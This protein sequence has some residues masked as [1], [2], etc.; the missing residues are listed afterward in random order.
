MERYDVIVCGGGSAG[1]CTA[2]SAA[3][4]GCKTA[5]IEKYGMP[6]G[7]LTV[8]GNSSI[9]QFNNPFLHGN[10][11]VIGG[12]GWEFVRRLAA[13]G[14][15]RIPDMCAPYRVHWQYGVKVNPVAAAALMDRMLLDSGVSLYYGQPVVAVDASGAHLESVTISTKSGLRK[16]QASVFVDCT[17]D[18]DVCAWAGARYEA[19]DGHEGYQP[20]TLRY[21]PVGMEYAS[22]DYVLD[23]GDNKNHVPGMDATDSDALT[24]A[25]IAARSQMLEKM[26][27]SKQGGERVMAVAPAVGQREGRRISGKAY[28]HSEEYIAGKVFDDSV[29]YSFWFVDIHRESAPAC[30]RYITDGATPTVRLR[31]MMPQGFSNLLCAGRCVSSDRETNSALRVKGSCMAMGEAAGIAAAFTARMAVPDTDALDIEIVKRSL[32]HSGAIVPGLTPFASFAA[33]MEKKCPP[34]KPID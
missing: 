21:Y 22:D 34:L 25:E 1:F 26:L 20:G 16:L 9:D 7:V 17:G 33:M 14:F 11:M 31:A 27:H 29:C 10:N 12:I 32:H 5:L 3:R 30:I 13:L 18:G 28:M 15:A 24:R 19:G 23:Y 8:T 6:G 2:V 4:Q